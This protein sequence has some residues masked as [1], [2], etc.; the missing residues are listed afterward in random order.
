M[1]QGY[2]AAAAIIQFFLVLVVGL[3]SQY[4]LRRRET[5]ILG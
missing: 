2:A 4:I 1:R 5:R 3:T